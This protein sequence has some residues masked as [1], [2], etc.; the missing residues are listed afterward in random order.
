M[1]S[2]ARGRQN[3][4][5]LAV[6]TLVIGVGLALSYY[7]ANLNT[8]DAEAKWLRRSNT[9]VAAAGGILPG[10]PDL[11]QLKQRLAAFNVALGAPVFIRIFKRDFE[12]ELWLLRDGALHHFATYPI[13]NWSGNL[14]PKQREGDHQSPEGFYTVDAKALNP[15]S[16]W[17]RS[18]NLGYPNAFDRAHNR[19]GTFLMVHG[20]CGSVGCYAMT[21]PV[22]DELWQLVTAA[23]NAGQKRFHVHVFPF[24]MTEH[25]LANRNRHAAHPFWQDLKLGF[26][27][28]EAGARVPEIAVCGK[29]Y[30][31]RAA[32]HA[33]THDAPILSKC[34]PPS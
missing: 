15:Q 19:T 5:W 7:Y 25:N 13:C 2:V 21:D 9:T 28:F 33:G 18:F 31:V 6:A 29:Q 22:I 26:D 17:H 3:R 23:L 8:D 24:R 30:N 4:I 11:G 34:E 16:R 12:L 14:G 32:R 27:A 20:G 10:T 1:K